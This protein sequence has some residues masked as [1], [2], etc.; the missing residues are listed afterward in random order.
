MCGTHSNSCSAVAVAASVS[1]GVAA[2]LC[3]AE[4]LKTNFE[5]DVDGCVAFFLLENIYNNNNLNKIKLLTYNLITKN[6]INN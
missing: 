2:S 6:P 3:K 1:A 5:V 4:N